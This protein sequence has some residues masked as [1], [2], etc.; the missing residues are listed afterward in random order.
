MALAIHGNDDEANKV[1]H[2]APNL[3]VNSHCNV[4]D[5]DIDKETHGIQCYS[6][7]SWFHAIGCNDE[8]NVASISA[9]Q[10]HLQPAMLKTKPYQSRFGSWK[11][12][13]DYC[14][15]SCCRL[16]KAKASDSVENLNAKIE[17]MQSNFDTKFDE[18]RN[19]IT[20]KINNAQ[21]EQSISQVT[22]YAS[23]VSSNVS[24]SPTVGNNNITLSS[25]RPVRCK[26]TIVLTPKNA[27]DISTV[28][29]LE[30]E[31][32][33]NLSNI[34]VDFLKS[35]SKGK[36][37]VGFPNK[38]EKNKGEMLIANNISKVS[39]AEDNDDGFVMKT[40]DKMLPKLSLDNVPVSIFSH[41][42]STI[43]S[44]E[45]RELQKAH[46]L[47]CIKLKNPGVKDLLEAG[48]T[49]KVVYLNPN[50]SGNSLTVA[51][52]V[53]PAVRLCIMNNQCGRLFLGDTSFPIK[54]RYYV[55]V[56]Y[57]CQEIG[58]I[59][60]D[61]PKKEQSSCCLY[62]GGSHKSATCESKKD[63]AKKKCARCS[64]SSIKRFVDESNSH[65]AAS[66]ECPIMKKEVLKLE[67]N[68]ELVSK[69]VM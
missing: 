64:N 7:E 40:Q 13:C 1:L 58:H 9:F 46:I 65:N 44:N 67:S 2:S 12:I 66:H 45:K 49:V 33:N 29:A 69:N 57:Q 37:F 39:D 16:N 47:D 60:N 30:N 25:K 14:E 35:N 17:S 19:F 51:I 62:C 54:D 3:L 18:L 42:E 41:I 53:S 21:P 15:K 5:S 24:Q 55:K 23:S 6:C 31:V 4:C 61:C 68:T 28:K 20:D 59:S 11:W 43:S 38:D 63:D 32:S 27:I 10:N 22:T 50:N 8:F 36:I 52:K 56:C 34:Q 26:E 48:H